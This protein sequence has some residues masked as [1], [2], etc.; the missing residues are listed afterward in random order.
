[1]TGQTSESPHIDCPGLFDKHPSGCGI[2]LDLGSEGRGLRTCRRWC[3][4]NHRARE[5]SLGLYDHTEAWALLLMTDPFRESQGEDVTPSH[6][7]SP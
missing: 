2:D 3:K 6:G 7:D 5:E 1:M 4:E